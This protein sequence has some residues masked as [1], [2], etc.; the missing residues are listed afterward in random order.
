MTDPNENMPIRDSLAWSGRWLC[1]HAVLL[2][3]ST[4]FWTALVFGASNLVNTALQGQLTLRD[5]VLNGVLVLL[6]AAYK[7]AGNNPAA[8]YRAAKS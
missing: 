7:G 4:S 8:N 5:C 3:T 6:T 1:A 2:L